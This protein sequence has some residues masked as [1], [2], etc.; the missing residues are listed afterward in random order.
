MQELLSKF[1]DNKY[2]A[3]TLFENDGQS[4]SA[5][6]KLF[7]HDTPSLA[8]DVAQGKNTLGKVYWYEMCHDSATLLEFLEFL[9]CKIAK[10]KDEKKEEKDG[11]KDSVVVTE[12]PT[13]EQ[14]PN[15]AADSNTSL[16]T[17]PLPKDAKYNTARRKLQILKDFLHDYYYI[18]REL[19]QMKVQFADMKPGKRQLRRIQRQNVNYNTEYDSEEYVD[20]EDDDVDDDD[21]DD[22]EMEEEE[23]D[24][25]D[26]DDDEKND[27]FSSNGRTKRQRT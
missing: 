4:M 25:D 27:S 19:E 26:D 15:S 5:Q 14:K 18:L 2:N 11:E 6:F 7:Y 16:N 12:A 10:P 20:D 22:D 21:D 3:F 9:D 23:E 17:N 1:K 13:V 24:D 8:H